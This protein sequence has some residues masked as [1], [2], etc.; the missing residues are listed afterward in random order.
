MRSVRAGTR[1]GAEDG[2][3][4]GGGEE[5]QGID[6][7]GEAQNY[8]AEGGVGEKMNRRME[9]SRVVHVSEIDSLSKQAHLF[10]RMS[11][12]LENRFGRYSPYVVEQTRVRSRL[13][14][15]SA[16]E[17]ILVTLRL[18]D[19]D[20]WDE[21]P[22]DGAVYVAKQNGKILWPFNLERR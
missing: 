8:G 13:L 14:W 16:R 7:A 10:Y 4:V 1:R 5:D 20:G 17:A 3:G 22:S 11:R 6:V 12:K 15:K 19:G 21:L 18:V 9:T 2:E